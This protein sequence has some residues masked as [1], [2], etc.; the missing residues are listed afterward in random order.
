MQAMR[1]HRTGGPDVL[2]AEIVPDPVPA[3]SE[4]VVAVEAA[5]VNFI[6]CY[7]RSGLYPQPLPFTPGVEG[8]GTVCALGAEVTAFKTGDRV[9]WVG[10]AGSYAE[11]AAIPAE[12][13][14][15]LPPEV[16]A[17]QAATVLLQGLTAQILTS[18]TCPLAP[19]DQILVHSGAGGVGRL[20][21][22]MARARGAR[23]IA[24]VGSAG[25]VDLVRKLGAERV[26]DRSREDVVAACREWTGGAGVRAVFDGIGAATFDGSL[27][28]LA[29]RG[30]LVLF[31][32]SSGPV[33]PVDPARLAAGS[34]F[35]TRPSLF[36]YIAERAALLSHAEALFANLQAGRLQL[37]VDQTFPLTEAAAAHRALESGRTT[38]K[39][40]LLP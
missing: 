13:L 10:V 6:D 2:T 40:L 3:P 28:I 37:L 5:G 23:V 38:G 9:A 39:L 27:A 19:G 15:P 24:T 22:Q 18:E 16:T 4:V 12:R 34:F 36:H 29:R 20:L 31:G 26:V 33:A 30:M 11:Q 25:K 8:A 35:L 21:V 1:I 14:I 7:H 32:Q 17:Q